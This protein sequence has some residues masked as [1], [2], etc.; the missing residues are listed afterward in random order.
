MTCCPHK[1][2]QDKVNMNPQTTLLCSKPETMQKSLVLESL[3][4]VLLG[5]RCSKMVAGHT[6]L[7]E[8]LDRIL[9]DEA[10]TIKEVPS[11]FFFN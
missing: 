9:R 3:W 10:K 11:K 7:T 2:K 5:T 8:I 6:W 4:K 1:E